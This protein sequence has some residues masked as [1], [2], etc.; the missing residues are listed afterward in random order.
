MVLISRRARVS[1]EHPSRCKAMLHR[2][3]I[4]TAAIALLSACTGGSAVNFE[5]YRAA[6]NQDE[7]ELVGAGCMAREQGGG[8]GGGTHE[9]A[10]MQ[11]DAPNGGIELT[12]LLPASAQ[13]AEDP[14]EVDDP[15][16]VVAA[17]LTLSK[18]DLESGDQ[19]EVQF[20]RADGAHFKA[21]HWGSEDCD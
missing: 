8:A 3:A 14:V 12:Y 9:Y 21:V 18:S 20:D 11:S 5:V 16:L 6:P 13:N 17:M 2:T 1:A 7:L 19:F 4:L 15:D 10:Q